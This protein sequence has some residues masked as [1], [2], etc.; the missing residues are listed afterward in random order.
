MQA[1]VH[2]NLKSC[3]VMRSMA[4]QD[5]TVFLLNLTCCKTYEISTFNSAGNINQ[6][7]QAIAPISGTH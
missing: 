3:L 7:L 4:Q 2:A 5:V 6:T 1:T